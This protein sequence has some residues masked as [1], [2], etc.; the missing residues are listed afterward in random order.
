[1]AHY[2]RTE[3]SMTMNAPEKAFSCSEVEIHKQVSAGTITG[4]GCTAA[5]KPSY[6]AFS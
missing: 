2:V 5:P 6:W 3:R 1:M 4:L